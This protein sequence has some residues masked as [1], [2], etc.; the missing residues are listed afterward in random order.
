MAKNFKKTTKGATAPKKRPAY[1][2]KTVKL[3]SSDFYNTNLSDILNIFDAVP[4]DKISIPV[5]M[6]RALLNGDD[7]K[8]FTTI[9]NIRNTSG[10]SIVVSVSEAVASKIDD[11][12]VAIVRCKKNYETGEITYISAINLDKG[13]P[14]DFSY[15]DF[16]CEADEEADT[17]E[18]TATAVD[19]I[20]ESNE[21]E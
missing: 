10:T 8:G 1:V 12:I 2:N 15:E 16:G 21:E 20:A 4:F 18:E 6:S 13:T 5:S 11:S 3:G 19:V 9:G 17:C 14:V 7:S